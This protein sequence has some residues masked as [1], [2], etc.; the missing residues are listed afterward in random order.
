MRLEFSVA[1][2]GGHGVDISDELLE[3]A[4]LNAPTARF[5][6]Q[7]MRELDLPGERFDAVTC[8]F[9]AIGYALDDEGVIATLTAAARHLD[10]G[11]AM[12]IEFLHEP[13]LLREA[14][15]LRIR[16]FPLTGQGGELVRISR[17]RSTTRSTSWLSSSNSSS[18]APMGRICAGSSHR[19][20]G[21]SSVPDMRALLERAGLEAHRFVPAYEESTEFDDETFH[22][23]VLATDAQ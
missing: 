21:S 12:V 15:P 3:L 10:A 14:S 20:I 19:R 17:T 4:R 2:L 7:D 22:V 5:V 6:R 11:G 23:I 9:D 13:A 18:F 1:R 16:T 8:L